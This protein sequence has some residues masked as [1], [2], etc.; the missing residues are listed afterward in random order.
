MRFILTVVSIVSLLS[1]KPANKACPL[2]LD[3]SGITE[4]DSNVDQYNG[5]VVAFEGVVADIRKAHVNKPLYKVLLGQNHLWVGGHGGMKGITA[6]ATYRILGI[7]STWKNDKIN[8]RHNDK[9]YFVLSLAHIDM[10]SKQGSIMP[11]AKK[12]FDEWAGGTIPALAE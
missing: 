8:K 1:F 11:G 10:E 5:K 2:N 3:E 12:M 9:P 6:G 7:V 4:I